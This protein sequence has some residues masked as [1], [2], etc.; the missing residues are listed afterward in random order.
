[1]KFLKFLTKKGLEEVKSSE[2]NFDEAL[3]GF[4]STILDIDSL[5]QEL[6]TIS[7]EVYERASS[8]PSDPPVRNEGMGQEENGT[9][10][11]ENGNEISTYRIVRSTN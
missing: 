2:K 4:K 3:N 8:I 11:E 10:R 6:Q 5:R 9:R 1:M 7:Q